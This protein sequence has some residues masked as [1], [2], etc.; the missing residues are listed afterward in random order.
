MS[1]CAYW[2][3]LHTSGAVA[4]FDSVALTGAPF[5]SRT[6]RKHMAVVR[7]KAKDLVTEAH[8]KI[9]L[10]MVRRWDT[11]ILPPFGTHD[12]VKR[13]KGGA[14]KLNSKVARSLM[15]WRHYQFKLHA[16]GVFLRAGKELVSPDERYTS[17]T[18]AGDY[19]GKLN[20][21]HSKEEWTCR[22]CGVFHLRDPAASRCIFIKAFDQSNLP[23]GIV[24]DPKAR[25]RLQPTNISDASGRVT[26]ETQ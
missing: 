18:C 3:E 4:T 7:Q 26:G 10:D 2:C 9:A 16:K 21:K 19:C 13:P 1:T 8:R 23:N 22:H 20:V 6:R 5:Q 15:N 17:M 25:G 11:L 14:R 24:V 12:M